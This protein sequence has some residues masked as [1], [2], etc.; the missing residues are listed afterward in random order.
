MTFGGKSICGFCGRKHYNV[1]QFALKDGKE[2]RT[3]G[4]VPPLSGYTDY[5]RD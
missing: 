3:C 1:G 2:V 5:T 4:C